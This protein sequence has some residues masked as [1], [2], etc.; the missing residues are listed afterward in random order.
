MLRRQTTNCMRLLKWASFFPLP[1]VFG[2]GSPFN[3][4]MGVGNIFHGDDDRGREGQLTQG[5]VRTANFITTSLCLM[6]NM[7]NYI[8]L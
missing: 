2:V 4:F 8:E 7:H 1:F 5:L 6:L 3:P